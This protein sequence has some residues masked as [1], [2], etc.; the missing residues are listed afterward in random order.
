MITRIAIWILTHGH[1]YFQLRGIAADLQGLARRLAA[2]LSQAWAEWEDNSHVVY[3]Y[4]ANR[5]ACLLVSGKRQKH[6]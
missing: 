1:L 2:D 5:V 6:G 4:V 3:G